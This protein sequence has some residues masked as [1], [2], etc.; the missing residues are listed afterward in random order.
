MIDERL[1]DQQFPVLTI[2]CVKEPVAVRN[3]DDFAKLATDGQIGLHRDVRRVPIVDIV[4]RELVV[5]L[6][7]AGIGVKS[8]ERTRV[9][10]VS[11]AI[12]AIVVGIGIAGAVVNKVERR[13]VAPR[14][15]GGSTAARRDFGI[16]P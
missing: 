15:P 9:E 8:H 5:P 10:I 6:Q 12:V 7:L 2:E 11:F 13:I 16:R 3:H 14:H 1:R 4:R